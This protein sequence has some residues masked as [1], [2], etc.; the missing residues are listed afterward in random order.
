VEASCHGEVTIQTAT[1]FPVLT[2]GAGT[3]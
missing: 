2:V 3:A 1:P